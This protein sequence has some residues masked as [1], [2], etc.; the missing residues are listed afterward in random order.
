M[1]RKALCLLTLAGLLAGLGSLASATM[2]E[3]IHPVRAQLATGEIALTTNPAT[4]V[5]A[6]SQMAPGAKVTTPL[7]VTNAGT[8]NLRYALTA[9]LNGD[10]TI[11]GGYFTQA[12]GQAHGGLARV[13]VD[14]SVEPA[15]TP[16]T[17]S[18][19]Y[20]PCWVS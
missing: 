19:V 10:Q 17:D 12:G 7:T 5:I 9:N 8:L 11:I 16:S 6:Y 20:V 14:G 2:I 18:T 1:W 13:K 4:A 3:R 15:F